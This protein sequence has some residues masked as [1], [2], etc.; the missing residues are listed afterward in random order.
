LLDELCTGKEHADQ[1]D[2]GRAVAL[3]RERLVPLLRTQ[4][5]AG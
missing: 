3:V 4:G 1:V 2:Y 5:A